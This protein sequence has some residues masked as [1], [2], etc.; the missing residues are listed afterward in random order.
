VI[1]RERTPR[2]DEAPRRKRWLLRAFVLLAALLLLGW[3]VAPAALG[4]L[5]RERV[6]A[7][8]E[9]SLNGSVELEE[10]GI[11]HF[12]RVTLAGLAIRDP[13]GERVLALESA[14]LDPAVLASLRGKPR[15]SVRGRGLDV[16]AR[17]DEAGSWNFAA[18]A[19]PPAE[20]G[21]GGAGQ[22]GPEQDAPLPDFALALLVEDARIALETPELRRTW[23]RVDVRLAIEDLAEPCSLEVTHEGREVLAGTFRVPGR[24]VDP[25]TLEADLATDLALHLAPQELARL[26]E[27]EEAPG[28]LA[29]EAAH[30][31]RLAAGEVRVAGTTTLSGDWERPA[32]GGGR[33]RPEA[34]LDLELGAD[35]AL[36]ALAIDSLRLKS[37]WLDAD[38][39]G[40]VRRPPDEPA[41]L[42][43]EGLRGGVSFVPDT[44]QESFGELLPCE[45]SGATPERL[46]LE[47]AGTLR[48][49]D[50]LA[51]LASAQG[52]LRGSP[53]TIGLFGLD[54]RGD[55]EL[56]VSGGE[57]LLKGD[58]GVG[59]G[60]GKLVLRCPVMPHVEGATARPA[61]LQVGLENA[62]LRAAAAPLLAHVHPVFAG[63]EGVEEST[64]IGNASAV[65]DLRSAEDLSLAALA[66]NGLGLVTSALRGSGSLTLHEA[67]LAGSPLFEKLIALV[68]AE[69]KS[70]R[71]DPLDF[72]IAA[73]ALTYAKPWV[74]KLAGTPTTFGGSVG[75]DR[76]L[77]L[78][79]KVPI[80]ENL[81]GRVGA[82]ASLRGREL[83]IPIRGTWTSPKVEWKGAVEELARAALRDEAEKRLQ[84]ELE[85]GLE[86]IAK[87]VDVGDIGGL[88]EELGSADAAELLKRAD[89][90]WDAGKREE[91]R[92]I[93]RK[94]RDEHKLSAVYLLNRDRIKERG[95]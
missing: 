49:A 19:A 21:A 72:E 9:R 89:A 26:L 24:R 45:L 29:L 6:V 51:F 38:L 30:R 78:A 55:L 73:G 7:A 56:T 27:R 10:L 71:L 39:A 91:A 8:L 85:K 69:S 87:D 12:G 28:D 58:L 82:L 77:D 32:A 53:G 63:L 35:A 76:S 3:L 48:G 94:I 31:V 1:E 93:Y 75:F 22:R 14:E 67:T 47:L 23:E 81:A 18:L 13:A 46:E 59:G 83:A 5:V 41:T 43:L 57:V 11:T 92:G 50:V 17:Q 62:G 42:V 90:L 15:A 16:L 2:D 25:K 86:K 52:S 88:L 95:E 4:P 68:G 34:R 84:D 66:E 60:T 54:A 61:K 65:L 37:S 70:L 80:D 64:L 40:T 20:P 36:S 44:L 33:F 79:W 74:W